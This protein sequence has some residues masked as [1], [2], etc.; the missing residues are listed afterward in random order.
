MSWLEYV[1]CIVGTLTA[2]IAMAILHAL[3]FI[4][5]VLILYWVIF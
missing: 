2:M 5:G 4:M 1:L 3:P